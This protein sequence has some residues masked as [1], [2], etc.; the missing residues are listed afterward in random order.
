MSSQLEETVDLIPFELR[1]RS[2][3]TSCFNISVRYQYQFYHQSGFGKD[4]DLNHP[5]P[6]LVSNSE[7]TL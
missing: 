1:S 6:I 2:L 5:H 7:R 4:L 3:F